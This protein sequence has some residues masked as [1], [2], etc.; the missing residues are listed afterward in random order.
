MPIPFADV[1][2]ELV[3]LGILVLVNGLFAL[4]EMAVM[5]SRKT[6]LQHQAESGDSGA[7]RALEVLEEPTSFLSTIQVGITLIG[8]FMGAYGGI[9]LT[10]FLDQYLSAIPFFAPYSYGLSL[11]SVVIIIGYFSLVFGEI[12]PKR[13]ALGN[14]ESIA[15]HVITPLRFIAFLTKPLVWFLSKSTE[16]VLRIFGIQPDQSPGVSE[17]EIRIMVRQGASAGVIERMEE[18]LVENAFSLNDLRVSQ[19][20]TPRPLVIWLDVQDTSGENKRLIAESGFSRFLVADGDLDQLLGLVSVNTLFINGRGTTGDDLKSSVTEPFFV[21]ETLSV[22]ELMR[23]LKENNQHLAVIIDEYGLIQGIVT[24]TDII[25]TLVGESAGINEPVESG[26]FVRED[27]SILI[28]GMYPFHEFAEQTDFGGQDMEWEGFNSLG[29]FILD[30]LGHIPKEG[31]ILVE[32]D[33]KFEI[34][35]MDGRRVDKI[36]VS[37]KADTNPTAD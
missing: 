8:I 10:A 22:S 4:S 35:D 23:K 5:S 31:E 30:R 20:M 18:N 9:T 17:E 15:S 27:G 12:V 25:N 36:L 37:K 34:M 32:G 28:D 7:K 13:I 24:L 26:F 21:L 14:P 19:V 1:V 6:R 11:G 16:L 33:F 2:T 3:I 29:G